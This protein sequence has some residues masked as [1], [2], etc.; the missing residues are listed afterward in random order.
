MKQFVIEKMLLCWIQCN[1]TSKRNTCKKLEQKKSQ[2]K[3][4]ARN[5]C[6]LKGHERVTGSM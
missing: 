4:V 5:N 1:F 2:F 6:M 3:N